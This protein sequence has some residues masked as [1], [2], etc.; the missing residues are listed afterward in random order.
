[1]ISGEKIVAALTALA[2]L[3]MLLRLALGARR[4]AS[5][6]RAVLGLWEQVRRS[7][8]RWIRRIKHG[9]QARKATQE[10]LQRVRKAAERDGNVITPHAFKKPG[11]SQ[12]SSRQSD[13][14]G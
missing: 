6:D 8:M 11:A 12:Q 14:E 10:V 2:C 1:M 7:V 13:D 4:T 3:V 5:F 9:K